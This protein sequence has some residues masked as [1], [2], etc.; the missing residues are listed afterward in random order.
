LRSPRPDTDSTIEI[1]AVLTGS[2]ARTIIFVVAKIPRSRRVLACCS[3][4]GTASEG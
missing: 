2:V 1:G 4:T 3:G